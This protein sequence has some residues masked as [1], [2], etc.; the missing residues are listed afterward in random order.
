MELGG[1]LMFVLVWR[2]FGPAFAI[3]LSGLALVVIGVLSLD[4]TRR[5]S[6]D[7]AVPDYNRRFRWFGRLLLLLAA[8]YALGYSVP[9]HTYREQIAFLTTPK[10]RFCDW[11]TLPIGDKH[12]HYDP[13]FRRVNENIIVEWQLVND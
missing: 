12:C 10:P 3:F 8:F 11:V 5:I 13:I 7:H 4:T 9:G 1:L 6:H 2:L